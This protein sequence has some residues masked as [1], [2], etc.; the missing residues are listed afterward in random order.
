M[1]EFEI[2]PEL[3]KKLV[4]LFKKDKQTYGKV[5]RKIKEVIS[6]SDVEHYKNPR[7]G[8]KDSKRV[9]IGHFILIFSYD[10]SKDIISFEDFGH[11]DDIYE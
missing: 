1:R 5:M 8:M 4:K 2:K 6:S 10:K 11:H 3:E 9:H 7:Y